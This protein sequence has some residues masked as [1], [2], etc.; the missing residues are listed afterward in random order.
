M[1]LLAIAIALCTGVLLLPS[2]A[3]KPQMTLTA[4][5]SLGS[6]PFVSG[7]A[8]T[9]VISG[10]GFVPGQ[11]YWYNLAAP[12]CCL[13]AH[14]IADPVGHISLLSRTSAPGEYAFWVYE[15]GIP[16]KWGKRS[17]PLAEISFKVE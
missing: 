7:G 15:W 11:G 16:V 5:G 2:C 6:G 17:T 1:K 14:I 10:T 3:G 9:Y 8:E 12:G 13:G 4:T